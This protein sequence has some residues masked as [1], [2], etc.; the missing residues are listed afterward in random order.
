MPAKIKICGI[1]T[2]EALDATIA[3]RADYAGLVFYPASPRA[4]TSNVA[5]ALTSRAAGQIA[6]VGLFVDADDAVI[7]DAL[8]AAKLNAL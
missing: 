1:S 4:V 7:A 8:V 2:P 5:G 3:A 6:M